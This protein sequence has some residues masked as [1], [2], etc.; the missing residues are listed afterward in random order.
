MKVER[1]LENPLVRR[2]PRATEWLL[3][4]LQ[5]VPA[6]R[7]RID[8]AF[9]A[10][11]SPLRRELRPY[12]QVVPTYDRLPDVGRRPDEVLA[13]LDEMARR[14]TERWSTGRVSGAVYHGGE[15]HAAFM[16]EVYR[17]FGQTNPLHPDVWPSLSKF[18]A[19]IVAM[20]ADMLGADE[21]RRSHGADVCG[22]VTSG[23]TESIL[24]AMKTYRDRA[25]AQGRR[26]PFDI[27][28]PA[29][30]HAAFDKAGAYFG[31]RVK[32]VPVGPDF[33]AD[34]AA[35]ARAITPRTIAMA[36]SAPSF[37]HGVID[38]IETLSN[39][40]RANEIGFHTDACLGGF[41]L[42]FADA[43]G[44][45]VPPFDFRLPG[46]TSMSVDTHKYGYAPKGTSV[47][48]YRDRALRRHQY[49]VATEWP[50]GLYFSPTLAG[51]RPGA[52]VAQ[53]WATMVRMGREGYRAA[54]RSILQTGR[55]IRE[56]I[57]AIEGLHV[58]GDPLWVIAFGS[59][60]VDV[61]RVLE[62]MGRRGWSLNG[63]HHPPCVHLAVTLRHVRPGVADAFL[64]DLRASVEEARQAPSGE[65]TLAPIYGMAAT[66]PTRGLVGEMLR[67]YVDLLYEP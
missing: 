3:S 4:K 13:H 11:L 21:A 6:A 64:R 53:C 60:E 26:G 9:D 16:T 37:P 10:L 15:E 40:A 50:G 19:E 43:A 51:S 24:L 38:P 57:E 58:L 20:A 22:T 33:R 65:E 44:I 36:A 34:P 55:R 30:A 14:E 39:L 59:D 66:V 8:E 61:Y 17:R 18:E 1:L 48:L 42:A 28:V 52:P 56:G 45:E 47:V 2:A 27:V 49:Y 32:K 23:G 25:L 41:V 62:A 31:I 63:L 67:R 54:A 12:A 5:K 35:M 46:V 29:T 7:R